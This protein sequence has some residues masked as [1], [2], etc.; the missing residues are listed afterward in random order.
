MTAPMSAERLAELREGGIT[1]GS[2]ADVDMKLIFAEIDRLRTEVT[3]LN[4]VLH[5]MVTESDAYRRGLEDGRLKWTKGKPAVPGW[6]W[7]RAGNEADPQ[8]TQVYIDVR[9]N[10]VPANVF[11][12]SLM[13][14]Q[15]AGPIPIPAEEG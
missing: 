3:F 7:H 12:G 1:Y 10:L 2:F 4:G 6:Y 11:I 8:V 15:W 5:D 9:D 13:N 14:G